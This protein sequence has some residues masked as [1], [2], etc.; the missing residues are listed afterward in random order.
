MET[1]KGY[2]ESIHHLSVDVVEKYQQL[3]KTQIKCTLIMQS[4]SPFIS[5]KK[6][7]A[8]KMY[9]VAE[10]NMF[11][12]LIYDLLDDPTFETHDFIIDSEEFQVHARQYKNKRKIKLNKF[13]GILLR[14]FNEKRVLCDILK[15]K[16]FVTIN[17]QADAIYDMEMARKKFIA[18]LMVEWPYYTEQAT[19]ISF[20][21]H[22]CVILTFQEGKK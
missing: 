16:R 14:D 1:E 7:V 21:T 8:A 19:D 17:T 4:K 6:K 12:N 10:E 22:D 13:L 3:L 20:K 11:N 18:A 5:V 9:E 15:N 2:I